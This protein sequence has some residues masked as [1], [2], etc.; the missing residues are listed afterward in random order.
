MQRQLDVA[1]GV[2]QVPADHDPE[3][4]RGR[5]DDREV[6][7]LAR[8]VVD[9]A[10]E[11]QRRAAG[12][13]GQV[14]QHVLGSQ[15]ALARSWAE[16]D[17]RV[18][19][20]VAAERGVA[21]DRVAVRREGRVLDHDLIAVRDGSVERGEQEVQVHRE[22][23]HDDDLV[24]V[25]ADHAGH[26]GPQRD[27]VVAPRAPRGPV[28]LDDSGRPVLELSTDVVVDALRLGSKRVSR[29]VRELGV[30]RWGVVTWQE[31]RVPRAPCHLSLV[32]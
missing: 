2:R 21:A 1:R 9:A 14:R 18:G 12:L 22:G 25:C 32:E 29:E 3:V 27:V 11:Q 30:A 6:H 24:V 31:E 17:D 19:G 4:A 16:P 5:G 26:R 10:Q 13:I 15:C 7:E 8:Q 23:V 20:V 28:A